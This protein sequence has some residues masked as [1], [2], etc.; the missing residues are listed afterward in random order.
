MS[1]YCPTCRG[2]FLGEGPPYTVSHVSDTEHVDPISRE[3]VE[4]VPDFDWS[5]GAVLLRGGGLVGYFKN[6]E[7]VN[8]FMSDTDEVL[9]L[10]PLYEWVGSVPVY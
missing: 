2:Y 7:Q 9:R 4:R 6:E 8:K 10:V 3:S 5:N 1:R